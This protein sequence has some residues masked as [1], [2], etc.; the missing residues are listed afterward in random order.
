MFVIVISRDEYHH[1]LGRQEGSF[2]SFIDYIISCFWSSTGALLDL[3]LTMCF[4]HLS[5]TGVIFAQLM[6]DHTS[7]GLV[8]YSSHGHNYCIASL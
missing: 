1:D 3:V 2:A 7:Y 5:N 6:H 4:T 8:W